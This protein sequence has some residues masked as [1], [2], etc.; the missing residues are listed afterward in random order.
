LYKQVMK[1]FIKS[2]LLPGIFVLFCFCA[3]Q[4]QK[5]ENKLAAADQ[6]RIIGILL[7]EKF[8]NAPEKIIYLT[9]ANIPAEVQKNFQPVKNKTVRFVAPAAA[10]KSELC[11]YEFGEFQTIDKFVSVT[12]G[13][14]RDGL[15]YD[16]IKD[17]DEWKAVSSIVI[18]ELL[19]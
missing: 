10:A 2:C 7:N 6:R 17:G 18:R 14:C 12:F 16:F 19:Y 8:K 4:A 13:S 9:T 11:A 5:T 15:A 3:A 1:Q